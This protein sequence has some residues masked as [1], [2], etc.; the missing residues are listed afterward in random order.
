MDIMEQIEV[1]K[2]YNRNINRSHSFLLNALDLN[3][4][5]GEVIISIPILKRCNKS[6]WGCRISQHTIQRFTIQQC[7]V[8]Q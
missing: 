2:L 7:T 5:H 1:I 6:I 3:K 8:D 4:A